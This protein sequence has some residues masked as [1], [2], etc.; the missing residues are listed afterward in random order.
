MYI[1]NSQLQI[2]VTELMIINCTEEKKFC[3]DNCEQNLAENMI[4]YA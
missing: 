4:I 3:F 2:I 1:I